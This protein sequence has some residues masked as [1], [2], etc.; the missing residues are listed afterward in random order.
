MSKQ[1]GLGRGL[2]A[3]IPAAAPG[4]SGLIT[5]PLGDLHP[6]PRQPRD[7]FDDALLDE[8][9]ISLAEVGMLQPI[10]ARPRPEGGYQ[11]VAGERRFRAAGMA[12]LVDV[13]VVVRHTADDQ[14]LTE[15]L[16]EN[17]H[18]ADLDPIEEATAYRQ[19]LDDFGMTHDALATKL[20][21]S[22]SAISNA[23]RLLALPEPVQEHVVAGSLSAGHARALLSLDERDEQVRVA[24]QVLAEGLSVRN[25]E[26][27]VRTISERH[28]RAADAQMNELASAARERS[29]STFAHVE[30][31]LV[32]ALATKVQ[33]K[34]SLKRGRLVI[35]F[36]GAE[37]LERL[38]DIV[39][40]G[41]GRDLLA[42]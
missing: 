18:R 38:L 23:L 12:G 32:D 42:G 27:L 11:I 34:G 9:A 28:A 17:V 1:G 31:R 36:S 8:L 14:L 35:D 16:V 19:L 26:E 33:I 22:R 40:R 37:D 10:V 3:L 29:A 20:G 39:G 4:E 7:H 13:P 15:A 30:Q 21:R 24:Q 41:A 2:G 6:N 25:T 5:V